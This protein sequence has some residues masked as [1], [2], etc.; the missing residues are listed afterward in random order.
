LDLLLLTYTEI[1]ENHEICFK[2]ESM[3]M[4]NL[5]KHLLYTLSILALGTGILPLGNTVFAT[6]ARSNEPPAAGRD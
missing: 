2:K 1:D 6:E 4:R 5:K 3:I